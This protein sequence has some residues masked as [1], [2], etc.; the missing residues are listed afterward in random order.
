MPQPPNEFF[1]HLDDPIRRAELGISLTPEEWTALSLD[2]AS[3]E[4]L[5]RDWLRSKALSSTESTPAVA[6]PRWGVR[7]VKSPF[8][9]WLAF[10]VLILSAG[11]LT[12]FGAAQLLAAIELD[13][14]T[15]AID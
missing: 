10:S 3:V 13:H 1:E 4:A 8:A 2:P 6:R 9:F 11:G 15:A 14:A 12:Y 7:P 5:Y